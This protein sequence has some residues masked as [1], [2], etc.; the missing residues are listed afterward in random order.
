[1]SRFFLTEEA[2]VPLMI[3]VDQVQSIE[4]HTADSTGGDTDDIRIFYAD[5]N[6]T[7]ATITDTDPIKFLRDTR[8]ITI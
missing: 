3:N 1:M 4:Y 8:V 5:S 2:G 6:Y 7:Y